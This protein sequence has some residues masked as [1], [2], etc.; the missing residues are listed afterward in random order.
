MIVIVLLLLFVGCATSGSK[1]I[2]FSEIVVNG[3]TAFG[4]CSNSSSTTFNALQLEAVWYD[5]SGK[6]VNRASC[7]SDK[8]LPAYGSIVFSFI[9]PSD[10]N[11]T[12]VIEVTGKNVSSSSAHRKPFQMNG[13]N[14]TISPDDTFEADVSA[15]YDGYLREICYCIAG[16]DSEG[17]LVCAASDSY[18][19]TWYVGSSSHNIKT[20]Y[21]SFKGDRS[22][23]ES[24]VVSL[25]GFGK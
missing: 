5:E 23:A 6:V 12:P 10:T 18:Y 8:V 4:I 15:N 2:T 17:R 7:S 14:M 9:V 19:N 21:N 13:N 25:V 3:K 24:Y 11:G 22:K 16:Y 1:A 20:Y